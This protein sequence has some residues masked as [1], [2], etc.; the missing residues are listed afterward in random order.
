MR[1]HG[2]KINEIYLHKQILRTSMV[3]NKLPTTEDMLFMF[4]KWIAEKQPKIYEKVKNNSDWIMN[5]LQEG[6]LLNVEDVKIR[7]QL[8]ALWKQFYQ[9]NNAI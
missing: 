5:N 2:Q 8:K 6:V 7:N 4:K 1:C 9:Q 3:I